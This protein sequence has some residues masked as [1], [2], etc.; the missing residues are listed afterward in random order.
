MKK[1][2]FIL[3]A[4]ML[5]FSLNAEEL[6]FSQQDK[7][8]K[9]NQL[10]TRAQKSTSNS[11][12]LKRIK[13]HLDQ[14]IKEVPD[15]P[16]VQELQKQYAQVEKIHTAEALSKK[17]HQP[18]NATKRILKAKKIPTWQHKRLKKNLAILEECATKLQEL[19]LEKYKKQTADA[20]ATIDQLKERLGL[21]PKKRR[22]QKS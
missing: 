10:L 4:M 6:T 7:L 22:G 9:A 13:K 1:T 14:L 15:H 8:K 21:N 2:F 5:S 19:K 17:M 18:L 16:Q 20:K 12:I 11:F 3:L